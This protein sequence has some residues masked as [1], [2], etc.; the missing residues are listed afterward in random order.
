MFHF[1]TLFAVA[2]E[3]GDDFVRRLG[4]GGPWLEQARRIAPTLVAT[5]LLRHQSKS[6]FLSHDIWTAPEAYMR[7]R[8]NEAVR[9]L[10][11]VRKEVAVASFE[12]GAFAFPALQETTGPSN[13]RPRWAE[14]LIPAGWLSTQQ[15]IRRAVIAGV[16]KISGQP[17]APD[18]GVNCVTAAVSPFNRRLAGDS[19]DRHLL[20]P[21]AKNRALHSGD[22]DA[23]I[24][25]K[26]EADMR[27]NW[28]K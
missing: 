2:P 15:P 28:C 11:N 26:A 1:I 3:A 21:T 6:L 9:Q 18:D 17:P 20:R 24:S 14:Y 19:V 22:P 5:D 16:G 4:T 7:A 23:G 27:R 10:L 12:I 8:D 13:A 25:A